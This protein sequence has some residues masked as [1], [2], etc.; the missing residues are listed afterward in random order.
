MRFLVTFTKEFDLWVESPDRETVDFALGATSDRELDDMA[1]WDGDV[2][3]HSIDKGRET[4]PGDREPDSIATP[5]GFKH[6]DD[7]K[8]GA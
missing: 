1:D 7:V 4:R 3:E 6:P 8:E 2:W 5:E